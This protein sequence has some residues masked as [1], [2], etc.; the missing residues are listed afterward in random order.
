[1][2]GMS[3]HRREGARRPRR[4]TD[5]GRASSAAV[6][7]RRGLEV[8]ITLCKGSTSVATVRRFLKVEK[9]LEKSHTWRLGC[10]GV[11]KWGNACRWDQ[12]CDKGAPASK[13][14][15][16]PADGTNGPTQ[17]PRLSHSCGKGASEPESSKVQNARVLINEE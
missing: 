12:Q 11:Q 13:S 4:A 1:M 9:S 10:A 16:T 3:L 17:G 5:E 8:E 2:G 14:G 6:G 7:L 15:E